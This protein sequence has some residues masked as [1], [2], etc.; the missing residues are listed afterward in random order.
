MHLCLTLE[1]FVDFFE[2]KKSTIFIWSHRKTIIVFYSMIEPEHQTG[3][4]KFPLNYLFFCGKMASM[5][6][7][8]RSVKEQLFK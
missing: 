6:V 3:S 5:T 2:E 1:S 4:D 7:S 8:F